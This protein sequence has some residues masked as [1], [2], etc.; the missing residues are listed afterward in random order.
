[1]YLWGVANFY[2]T[3]GI[4]RTATQ[5]EVRKAF[6]TLAA[7]YHPDQNKD[8]D[9][10]ARF[11]EVNEA[12]QT[13]GDENKRAHYD[14]VQN[15]F[16]GFNGRAGENFEEALRDIFGQ[17][18]GAHSRGAPATNPGYNPRE[19]WNDPEPG[20]EIRVDVS[21]T[22]EE[23]LAGGKKT[24]RVRGTRATDVCDTCKGHGAQPGTRTVS[25][26]NC[27]GRGHRITPNLA[28]RKCTNCKGLGQIPLVPCRACTG[29]GK[30]F[31]ERDLTIS[32]PAGISEGQILRIAG[33]GGAGS[34]PGDLFVTIR[35]QASDVYQ[36]DGLDILTVK[37]ITLKAAMLG[38]SF[39]V[40][41]P[42]GEEV[43]VPIAAGTQPGSVITIGGL[44]V[45][46][47]LSSKKGDLKVGIKVG[48]P[49]RIT[50][51]G[52]KLLEELFD[53]LS[54]GPIEP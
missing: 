54:R 35:V 51:R 38:G 22:F 7:K 26:G 45:R 5:D 44:G 25:C 4:A 34:P 42:Y 19:T 18:H 47:S 53:E 3:L 37:E 15:P 29:T 21:M 49:K 40:K 36:R 27:G 30:T 28:S 39:I 17:K 13:L 20:D 6:R 9:A 2:D 14:M 10:V 11:K 23:S 50:A 41:S 48:L 46:H 12:W 8:P 43:E 16:H 31:Q 24:V 1:M 52:K 32:I 33:Q